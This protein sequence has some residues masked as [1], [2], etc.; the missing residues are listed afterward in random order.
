MMTNF[1]ISE[2]MDGIRMRVTF[3][4]LIA[5]KKKVIE[6]Y[7]RNKPWDVY[8]FDYY[9]KFIGNIYMESSGQVYWLGAGKFHSQR[10]TRE[11][12]IYK[13]DVRLG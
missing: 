8:I 4:S 9:Q 2:T 12:K 1:F 11:G 6:V 3:P 7:P 13:E 5:L 10:L